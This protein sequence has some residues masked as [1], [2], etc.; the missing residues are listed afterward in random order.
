MQ[1]ENS[2]DN[3]S[4]QCD[5]QIEINNAYLLIRII[6]LADCLKFLKELFLWW[7]NESN[8]SN[9]HNNTDAK[10]DASDGNHE[11]KNE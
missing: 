11:A 7:G 9:V 4:W 6:N 8:D 2:F 10:I 3:N 5:Q 1:D